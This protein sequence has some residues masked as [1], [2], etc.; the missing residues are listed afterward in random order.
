MPRPT[1]MLLLGLSLVSAS[2]LGWSLAASLT[3]QSSTLGNQTNDDLQAEELLDRLEAQG[4]L[5]PNTRRKLLER[6]LA[7]G[8]FEDALL[9][10]QPWLR[11]NLSLS[12]SPY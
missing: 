7:R 12:I 1:R 4:E 5:T 9:V 3:T 10:L 2:F 11:S 8:R 6:L